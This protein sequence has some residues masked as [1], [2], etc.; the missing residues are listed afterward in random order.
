MR[1]LL[2]AG[3]EHKMSP[4]IARIAIQF[5]QRLELRGNEVPAFVAVMQELDRLASNKEMPKPNEIPVEDVS[6]VVGK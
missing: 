5:M 4:E 3:W 6:E 1:E 2:K